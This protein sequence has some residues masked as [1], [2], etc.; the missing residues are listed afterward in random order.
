MSNNLITWNQF[1]VCGK[2]PFGLRYDFEDLCRQLFVCE[3]V[4]DGD[5]VHSNPNQAGIEIEPYFH[6]KT[7]RWIS[8]QAKFFENKVDYDQ[9]LNSATNI[10][11]Y[12]KG[13]LNCV[14]LFCNRP[15][16]NNCSNYLK[17]K[18]TLNE[19]DIDVILV[20]DTAIL[21]LVKKYHQIG[22]YYFNAHN[23]NHKWFEDKA[24]LV[25]CNLGD[26]HNKNFNIETKTLDYLS[27][28]VQDSYGVAY[29]NNKKKMLIS[30]IDNIKWRIGDYYDDAVELANFIE[31]IS[32]VD[33]VTIH[34]VCN[35]QKLVKE[36]FTYKID[37]LQSKI[38]K[39]NE[40]DK[41]V[42]NKKNQQSLQQMKMMMNLY[43]DGLNVQDN[44]K[45]LLNAKVLVI[46]GEAGTGKT[47][48][49]ANKTF[50]ILNN[51]G[52]ALLIL[53]NECLS[54]NN[55]IEQISKNLGIDI[56]FSNLIE[57]LEIIGENTNKIVPI[58]IDALNESWN[59]K[60]WKSALLYLLNELEDK[61][62]V[63]LVITLR[64][65]YIRDIIPDYFYN[66]NSVKMID[67]PGFKDI[68]LDAVKTFFNYYGVSFT[69]INLFS[70]QMYNPLF[71]TLY[72]KNHISNDVSL[73]GL[74][75]KI[76][77]TANLNI[78]DQLK[79]SKDG[80]SVSDNLVSEVVNC[81][82]QEM[83][84]SESKQ[85]ERNKIESL[86][87]FARLGLTP[88]VFITKMCN[89]GILHNYKINDK[90]Y[91]RFSYDQMNEFYPANRIVSMYSDEN[92]LRNYLS[93]DLLK[94]KNGKLYDI[95]N[96]NIFINA[97]SLYADKY[98]KECIDIID[99]I[100]DKRDKEFI[101][102]L[103]LDSLNWRS[104][105]YLA[106]SEVVKRCSDYATSINQLWNCFI[107]NS[108][109][110]NHILNADGLHK[111]LM[112]Y[113]LTDRD[114]YWTIFINE[115]NDSD[116]T[117]QI[118]EEYNKCNGIAFNN[119]EQ[120]RLMLILLSWFLTSSNRYVRDL[121]SK[122]M[123]TIL[124]D[125]FKYS[126]Y[127]L[128]LFKDVNDPY[129]IQ[130]L[131]GIVFGA[132]V[133]II[134]H[135]K[136]E[137]EE[138]VEY[139]YDIV[140]NKKDA[141]P[142]ILLRDYARLIIEYYVYIFSDC[143]LPFDLNKIKP[144]Y[145]STP[146]PTECDVDYSKQE[147][148]DGL[149][150]IK[151]SMRF[152][153]NGAYGDFGR[154]VF[155]GAIDEFDIDQ[156]LVFNL[157]MD[158]IINKLKYDEDK[159]TNYDRMVSSQDLNRHET[160][161]TE[162]IGKK[163]QWI[164]M[165]NFLARISDNYPMINNYTDEQLDFKGSYQLRIRDFDP[166]LN[167]NKLFNL[168]YPN[169]ND[170]KSHMDEIKKEC[171]QLINSSDFDKNAW[172][173]S[174]SNFFS[175]Q[176]KDLILVDENGNEWLVLYRYSDTNDNNFSKDKLQ[177]FNF[178]YGYFVND[179]QL[180]ILKKF[181]E[182]KVYLLDS[183]ITN[184]YTEYGLF[185]REYP[186]SYSCETAI[187]E[188]C[189]SFEL[190]TGE[191]KEVTFKNSN[192]TFI[193]EGEIVYE[194]EDVVII[195]DIGNRKSEDKVENLIR[196]EKVTIDIG[197]ILNS[198][199]CMIWSEQYDG[200]KTNNISIKHPCAKL[201]KDLKLKQDEYDG[202]YYNQEGELV[203]FDSELTKQHAG[204][205]IKKNEF[206][207]FLSNNNYKFVWFVKAEKDVLDDD[208]QKIAWSDWMGLLVYDGDTVKGDYYKRND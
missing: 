178:M 138:L 94:I 33:N 99:Q 11:K 168:N 12:Y 13:K 38:E 80:Y 139:I 175:Y 17:I 47:Q 61:K 122:A 101:F 195:N 109:K 118:I 77:W 159:F 156:A 125:N 5:Y 78:H 158:H 32:D 136:D 87:I 75:N 161:K 34:N 71:L 186:W 112:K 43:D 141:Y 208:P 64:K 35:W 65:E 206:D 92:E 145:K 197:K 56:S 121:T 191:T 20:C 153:A 183:S 93:N 97:C 40:V 117:I 170:F 60:L 81:I 147:Y 131:Y 144:P 108:L 54:D 165:F 68:T 2:N 157:A 205:V 16:T 180:S 4:S 8:F 148:I 72:C 23:I 111:F 162:R 151:N 70:S 160:I 83:L 26:R 203:S 201:I 79:L 135:S 41:N 167:E 182:K 127:L 132:C 177:I 115:F 14:Y 69:P 27:I 28:F 88:R 86:P 124:T 55:M 166:T 63:R 89:E 126:K 200:S 189:K 149:F 19:Q 18:K 142:D 187:D 128:E 133:R 196:E 179:K 202:Y 199:Q 48:L 114:F 103:Y 1:K 95:K 44:E 190:Y 174:C 105:V 192:K 91:L 146:L 181:A 85:L 155:Q 123:I 30:E 188:Q 3:F 46:T 171:K 29:F 52:N 176:K 129:I 62:Y 45:E 58:F 107:T 21:D 143:R 36:K 67:H 66:N 184:S 90:E 7:N 119:E 84:D 164:T 110:P 100:D 185:N 207:K 98:H 10:I 134:K 59:Q 22:T 24:K 154:Y 15:I 57:I 104:N 53:G 74:Y 120:I 42:Y 204:L 169:F 152:E 96:I 194:D 130:R 150:Y 106:L 116:R 39:T 172:L 163:Y 25:D 193:G 6:K 113:S 76:L 140:F 137:F 9:I 50:S 49:L 31:D 102:E 73:M 173:N 51:N 198:T 37:D 82:S